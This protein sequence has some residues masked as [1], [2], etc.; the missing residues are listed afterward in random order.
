M[1]FTSRDKLHQRTAPSFLSEEQV[2]LNGD[3][4]KS[5][6]RKLDEFYAQLPDEVEQRGVV[7]FAHYPLTEGEFL[8]AKLSDK[9]MSA[10]W[11]ETAAQPKE[12]RSKEEDAK[13]IAEIN[14][15]SN[16]PTAIRDYPH[17]ELEAL[18]IRRS[19]PARRGKWRMVPPEAEK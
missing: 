10:G 13:I 14:Q 1:V 15:V 18:V 11:R 2:S 12:P 5:D 8:I 3:E 16:A 6:L 17:D 9:L 7:S 4:L 19:I